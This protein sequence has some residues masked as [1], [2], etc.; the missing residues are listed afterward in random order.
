[1]ISCR[2]FPVDWE[3]GNIVTGEYMIGDPFMRTALWASAVF[4]L[5]GALLFAFPSS[6]VSRL[7][8]LPLPVTPIY[9]ALLAFFILL[10]GGSYAWLAR[11]PNIDRPL[12]ALGAIGKAGFFTIVL[13]FWLFAGLSLRAVGAAT[14]DLVFAAIF[15]GWLVGKGNS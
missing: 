6:L 3:H 4:N 1:M 10:F 12:V 5:A 15:T 8:G 7:A 11:Q 13:I 14:G 9:G 2:Q